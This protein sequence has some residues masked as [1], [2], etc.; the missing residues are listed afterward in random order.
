[1]L[2]VKVEVYVTGTMEDL[3]ELGLKVAKDLNGNFPIMLTVAGL[4]TEVKHQDLNDS[5]YL[6]SHL[7]YFSVEG[8]GPHQLSCVP[9]ENEDGLNEE[10]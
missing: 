7:L 10:G 9:L 3:R 6:K 5:G 4:L 2:G 8:S 1:M